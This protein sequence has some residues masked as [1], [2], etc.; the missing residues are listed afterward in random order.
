VEGMQAAPFLL[1]L[2]IRA[3]SGHDQLLLAARTSF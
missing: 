2:C 3:A 1:K